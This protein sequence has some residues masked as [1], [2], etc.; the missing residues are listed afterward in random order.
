MKL[1][2][3]LKCSSR[4]SIN[5]ESCIQSVSSTL[6]HSSLRETEA[7]TKLLIAKRPQELYFCKEKEREEQWCMLNWF[8]CSMA[9]SLGQLSN[10]LDTWLEIRPNNSSL[11]QNASCTCTHNRLP[12]LAVTTLSSALHCNI[13]QGRRAVGGQ[14][15]IRTYRPAQ[16][17]KLQ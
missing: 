8:L 9:G 2:W 15:T 13:W 1:P 5:R 7:H 11:K 10:R 17:C 14:L 12:Q 6:S 4:V 16:I 3:Q